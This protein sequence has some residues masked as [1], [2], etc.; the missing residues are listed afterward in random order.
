[1]ILI[2]K[3]SGALSLEKSF[4]GNSSMEREID[5]SSA[6]YQRREDVPSWSAFKLGLEFPHK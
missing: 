2:E 5:L 1:M 3:L 6:K 4:N